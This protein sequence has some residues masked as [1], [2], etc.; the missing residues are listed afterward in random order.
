VLEKNFTL[1]F[2][3]TQLGLGAKFIAEDT[4]WLAA[5]AEKARSA[6]TEVGGTVSK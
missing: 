3:I 1:H 5:A 6:S 2:Y 4:G